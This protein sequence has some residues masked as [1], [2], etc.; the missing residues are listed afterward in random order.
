MVFWRYLLFH[1]VP[2]LIIG[3]AYGLH[4]PPG[5]KDVASGRWPGNFLFPLAKSVALGNYNPFTGYKYEVAG[6]RGGRMSKRI[7]VGLVCLAFLALT[8]S[9]LSQQQQQKQP[10]VPP[11][12]QG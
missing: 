7:L 1:L 9:A 8:G 4:L 2:K 12:P 5:N 6:Q 11:P 10:A 3:D